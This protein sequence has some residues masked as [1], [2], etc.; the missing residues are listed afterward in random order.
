VIT[1]FQIRKQE[2]EKDPREIV[3]EQGLAQMTDSS[4]IEALCQQ[5]IKDNPPQVEEYRSGKAGVIGWLMGQV[6]AKT[7]GKADPKVVREILTNLLK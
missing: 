2:L 7:G 6:M 4:A 1:L 5:V 3:E